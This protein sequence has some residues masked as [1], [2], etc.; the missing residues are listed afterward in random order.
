MTDRKK[1]L[2]EAKKKNRVARELRAQHVVYGVLGDVFEKI[3]G[4]DEMVDWVRRS[5]KNQGS[6]YRM[7]AK[8]APSMIPTHGMQGDVNITVNNQLK[9]TP[10]DDIDAEWE[11]VKDS[12][13]G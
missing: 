9:P 1:A 5:D 12:T 8:A 3:G 7:F 4:V 11:E 2:A 6:F 10:L 13:D